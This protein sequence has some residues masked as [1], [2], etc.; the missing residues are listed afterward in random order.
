MEHELRAEIMGPAEILVELVGINS[1]NPAQTGPRSG[2]ANETR[3]AEEVAA[4]CDR[5]GAE[6]WLDEVEPGR[7]N[8]YARFAGSRPGTV[9]VDVHLDTVSVEHM[10]IPPFAAEIRDGRVYGRG[11]VDTKASLAVLLWLLEQHPQRPLP[12]PTLFLVGTVSE[13]AGGLAG[14]YRF[15]DWAQENSISFDEM[16]VAEPTLCAPVYGHKGGVGIEITVHGSA[17]H[18]SKPHLGMNAIDGASRIIQAYAQ[19]QHRLQDSVDDLDPALA[20]MGA[21][22]LSV[23]EIS[24][25]LARNIIPDACHLYAGRRTVPGED[26]NVIYA[27]LAELAVE[28]AHPATVTTQMANG[29]GSPAFFQAPESPLIRRLS[30]LGDAPPEVATYGSNALVYHNIAQQIVVFGPGSIDQ[31]HQAIEWIDLEEI[32]RVTKIYANWLGVSH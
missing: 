2:E 18:S 7:S 13:E 11:S 28:A 31:A 14:A 24:G 20:P 29:R 25:G 23:T 3:L 4:R 5:L 15:S 16:I 19:E 32:G 26:P 1:V 8:V 30:E 27:Q 9:C 12:G 17:A 10:T 6:T 21:G 22:T